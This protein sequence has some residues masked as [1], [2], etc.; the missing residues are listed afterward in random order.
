MI[1]L[2]LKDGSVKEIEKPMSILEIAKSI[3]EGLARMATVGEV[4]GEHPEK[5]AKRKRFDELTPIYPEERLKLEKQ[6]IR[7]EK[8][9]ERV[10]LREE[11]KKDDKG[12]A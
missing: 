3:S 2:T 7:E 5:A 12:R 1:K 11:R 4:N 9:K 8:A 6:R 10:R